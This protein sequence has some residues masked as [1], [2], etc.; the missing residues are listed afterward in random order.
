MNRNNDFILWSTLSENNIDTNI[1]RQQHWG[2]TNIGLNKMS[3]KTV[4]FTEYTNC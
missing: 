1:H 2:M 4:T 3:S